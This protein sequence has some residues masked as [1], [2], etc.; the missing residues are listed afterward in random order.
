ML[1]QIITVHGR[2]KEQKGP[3]TGI[4]SWRHVKAVK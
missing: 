4:A 2:T 1:F 3:N